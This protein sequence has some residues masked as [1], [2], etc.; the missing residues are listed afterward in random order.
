MKMRQIMPQ[1]LG[2][3]TSGIYDPCKIADLCKNNGHCINYEDE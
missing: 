2:G 1:R 3:G